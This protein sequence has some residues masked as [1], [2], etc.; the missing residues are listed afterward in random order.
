MTSKPA[1]LLMAVAALF[2]AIATGLGA[3]ASHGL[4]NVLDARALESLRTG[5]DYQFF[6]SLGLFGICLLL[7]RQRSNK[8]LL[9]AGAS[10]AAGIVLFCG[11]VYASSLDGPGWISSL[12]PVGGI[13]LIGGWL[14]VAFAVL[15]PPAGSGSA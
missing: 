11:G 8:L 5:V 1:T 6:H 3:Y 10:I 9:A 2:I 4:D 15:K 12:A 7:G 13:G 14:V